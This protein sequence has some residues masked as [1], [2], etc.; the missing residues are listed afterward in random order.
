MG[1]PKAPPAPDYAAL[2]QQQGVENRDTANFNTNLN[3]VDQ[4][5]PQ[6]SL[7]WELRPG[8]DPQNPQAGD[9]IQRQTYSPDQ[10]QLY[11]LGNQ[12][13][14]SFLT[15]AQG[16]LARVADSMGKPFDMSGIPGVTPEMIKQ[17][18][19][20][21]DDTSR[22]RVEEAMMSRLRPQ[23]EQDQSRQENQLLNAGIER[24]S[25]A[26]NNQMAQLSRQQNDA[27]MQAVLAGGQEESRQSGLQQQI[28][29]LLQALHGQ[30][31]Q[32]QAFLRQLPLNE[33]NALRTGS[34]V[35]GPQFGGYYTGGQ[36]NAAPVYQAGQDQ[37]AFDMQQYMQQQS[38]YNALIGGLAGMGGQYFMGGFK[39]P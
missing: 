35:Q 18:Q 39:K 17:L 29:S 28:A 22:Q 15:T 19:G 36:A 31:V 26:W 5:T 9:Y 12:I 32:E 21:I 14:K 13:S 38:G 10:Q 37:A 30:G 3:R 4:Y 1:K 2:A 24:G 25:D 34:Q 6:G 16:G 23:Y 11:D 8:A 7:T 27:R 20:P 33:I